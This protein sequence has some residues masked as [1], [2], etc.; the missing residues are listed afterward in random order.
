MKKWFFG[1]L[2]V[3]FL[4]V[5]MQTAVGFAADP[6]ELIMN[7]DRQSYALTS[8]SIATGNHQILAPADAFAA[9]I[10]AAYTESGNIVTLAKNGVSLHF[11]IDAATAKV[12]Q[13]SVS[14]KT[15][16]KRIDGAAYVPVEF[17]GENFHYHVLRE[18][19]GNRVR[20]VEKT[21]LTAPAVSGGVK[22]GMD[23]LYSTR[24]R[25]VPTSFQKSNRLD[26]L[27][28]NKEDYS[29]AVK[30]I[31]PEDRGPLPTGP[32]IFSQDDFLTGMDVSH[33]GKD[34]WVDQWCKTEIVN[35]SAQ[36][37]K[38]FL[39]MK[40]KMDGS[41]IGET[42]NA[43]TLPFD[44][45]VQ[46]N[47]TSAKTGLNDKTYFFTKKLPKP[48]AE[49]QYVMTYYAR[50]IS[51]GDADSETGTIM[52]QVQASDTYEKST[53]EEVTLTGDWKRFD[54]LLTGVKNADS[55][56]IIPSYYKQVIQ[57]G[58]F[59]IQNVGPD[60]DVSYF[61]S[62]KTDLLPAELAPDAAWRKEALDRIKTVRKGDFKVIVKDRFGNVI[63]DAE[64]TFNMF[65]HEFKF[66]IQMDLEYVENSGV[67][68]EDK[69]KNLVNKLEPNFNA[70]AVGNSLK[71]PC[72]A[73][74]SSAAQKV[75]DVAK[76]K[77]LKYVRG[78]ALWM[79]SNSYTEDPQAMYD[80]LKD[81]RPVNA[82]YADLLGFME[83]HFA[84]M[85]EKFP[86][87]Y[88]WDVTNETHGR[89]FFTDVFGDRIFK[90]VYRIAT[91][92]L[93]HG[94]KR[95]LCDNRQFE[96]PY[97]ER[98][99]WFKAQGIDYDSLGMQGHSCCGSFD[100]D[101]NYRPTKFLEVWDRFA[102]E[103][104]KTFA[105][106]E[107]SIG[108]V[109]SEYGYE[110]QGDIMRDMMIA[111]FSHPACTGFNLW[112]LSDYWSDWDSPYRP[113]N[114][115]NN[116]NGAG[117]SPLYTIWGSFGAKPGIAQYQDL[118]YNK[119]WTRD[120]KTTTD[121]NGVGTVNGFY[122]DYDVTVKAN[123]KTKNV[124]AAFHKGYENVLTVVIK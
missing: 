51:G 93:T 105:V 46:L 110:G 64:V 47:I 20:L 102:Y 15:P 107:F 88:E 124:M 61:D 56:R 118:L 66:G 70:V 114:P 10:G 116:R 34:E 7:G 67:G 91:D 65:E 27:I 22:P 50:L 117:V 28:Y 16:A 86:E 109:F 35:V 84:E 75:I 112:W 38:S 77:G 100:P 90:D 73:R 69:W 97:W 60:A 120:A 94:Q 83:N 37:N 101:N 43:E 1:L 5:T 103:Y 106:T 29:D 36:D 52:F 9:A 40:V 8:V 123:G 99:D 31:R 48:T 74:D 2:I 104:Q 122:G 55:L 21:G 113:D 14:L 59:E 17:C 72:Y 11:T 49:D 23:T 41:L 68:Y 25:A 57:I 30:Q 87:I 95:M 79:P 98:L 54:F 33:D 19:S 12:G 76:S 53:S 111:A 89:T 85:D 115:A 32:V 121:K 108:S 81:S 92:K 44:K 78:H 13:M 4:A 6:P 42:D 58:G 26:D 71:W 63:P 62:S 39:S 3:M 119:W 96:A 82:R 80:L 24:H 18:R 45:A